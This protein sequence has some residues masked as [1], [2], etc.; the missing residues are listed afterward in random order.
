MAEAVKTLPPRSEVPT[1]YKWNAESVYASPQDWEAAFQKVM[2]D[3]PKLESFKGRL[4]ESPAAL[5]EAF[6]FMQDFM[7]RALTVYIYAYM[8]M[9]SDTT[10]QAAA[11]MAGRA[12]AIAGQAQ[13][14]TAFLDPELL[15][16]GRD[17]LDSWIRGEPRLAYLAHYVDDLFRQQAHVRSAEVEEV[18]GSVAEPFNAIR[19]T[20][21]M[22]VNA[23]LRFAPAVDS[24]GNEHTVAQSTYNDL[25]Q[26]P[27]RAL[28]RSA[29][30]SYSDG[31]LAMQNTLASNLSAVIKKDVF[32]ARARHYESALDAALFAH[33]IPPS[34]YHNL[35]ATCR[36]H[37]PVWHR[38]WDV[39]RRALKLDEILPYDIWA[40]ISPHP[41]EVPFETAIDWIC[42][43][44]APLGEEYVNTLRRGCLEL[45][46]VDR[47]PNVGKRE[48]AFSYGSP[49]TYPF[50]H[51]HYTD[52][53]GSMSVL[54][55]E[56]GHSMHSFYTRR[57]Q[58]Q[59]YTE[60]SLF[61]GE[62][63][64][65]FN[66]A[67]VR[68]HLLKTNPDPAFQIALIDEAM[69][70][71]HR[72]FFIMPILAQFE[73][74]TH[75]RAEQGEALTATVMN[76]LMADLFAEGYG[77]TMQFERERVGITWAEF[78]HLYMNFYVFQYATGISAAHALA[79]N[80]LAG[81]PGAA[82]RYLDMLNKGGHGYPID[83]LNGAGVDM[84]TPE[85]VEE[86]FRV[87]EGYVD[88]LAKLAG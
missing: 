69:G 11:A 60:Y 87:L 66:Q 8:S 73:L 27:D 41:P 42:E 76:E 48:G 52:R 26:H 37:L 31:Y 88:R 17:R 36:K 85:A 82:E 72:Y 9:A 2:A 77:N 54:A 57:S 39:R 75:R 43:G 44:L 35:I 79:N 12:G 71:L 59:V 7:T 4:G 63:A 15:A 38:Y 81:E 22:L 25:K 68:D 32:F 14:A 3:L 24:Q 20:M 40:P 49:S 56:L 1:E 47:Y 21:E 58:P 78:S 29:Y 64:S 13:A 74:E 30:A 51:M 6:D 53:V 33:N 67:M 65:N 45:R 16:I 61:V 55:H 5:A 86:T 80:I 28:R 19:Q 34:V 10:D 83:L 46:W 84:S 62:V 70:N 50:I 23:D 18:L